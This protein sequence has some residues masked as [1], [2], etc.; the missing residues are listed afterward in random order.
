M[1]KTHKPR[2]KF[3]DFSKNNRFLLSD[4]KSGMINCPSLFFT[5]FRLAFRSFSGFSRVFQF[6]SLYFHFFARPP[7]ALSLLFSHHI[8]ALLRDF[9]SFMDSLLL[10]ILFF[11]MPPPASE[12]H[13]VAFFA[14][15][16][17]KQADF[18]L[19]TRTFAVFSDSAWAAAAGFFAVFKSFCFVLSCFRFVFINFL[20]NYN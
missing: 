6:I 19:A 16:R 10:I 11:V 12:R 18:F 15:Y 5:P 2:I 4:S 8:H 14:F 17:A 3:L 13:F 9:S 1:Q 7:P 20:P